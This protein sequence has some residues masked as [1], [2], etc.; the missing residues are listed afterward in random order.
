MSALLFALTLAASEPAR[1]N[2]APPP[3][4]IKEKS[5]TV[6]VVTRRDSLGGTVSRF[7]TGAEIASRPDSLGGARIRLSD[8]RTGSLRTDS[9]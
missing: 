8:G 7:S 5:A 2:P 3:A 1:A 6:T 4:F 9:L